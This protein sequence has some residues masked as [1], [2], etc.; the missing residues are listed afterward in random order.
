[1]ELEGEMHI[2]MFV[3]RTFVDLEV[4]D[5]QG[6]LTLP[7]I[8]LLPCVMTSLLRP[9]LHYCPSPDLCSYVGTHS[10]VHVHSHMKVRYKEC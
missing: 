5:P 9:F 8:L 7:L 1:M 10:H 4:C 3:V 2:I 6:N